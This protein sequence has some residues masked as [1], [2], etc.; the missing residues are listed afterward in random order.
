MMSDA[1]PSYD[2]ASGF[3]EADGGYPDYLFKEVE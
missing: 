1:R 3:S 2:E